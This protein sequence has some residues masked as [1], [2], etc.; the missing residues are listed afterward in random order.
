ME[1]TKEPWL[2]STNEG[3]PED[4]PAFPG[5]VD[6]SNR[7]HGE[8]L[9]CDFYGD[10]GLVKANCA[11][12]IQCVNALAGIEDVEGWMKAVK[13]S[14]AKIETE[15]D[16]V[17]DSGDSIGLSGTQEAEKAVK[18]ALALFPKETK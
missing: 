18:E 11:R 13:N 9:I 4:Q 3:G 2:L 12:A 14:I 16:N 5:I 1:H 10:E 15:Y 8:D 17:L 6:G 7:P